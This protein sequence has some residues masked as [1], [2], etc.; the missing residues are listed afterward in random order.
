MHR[1]TFRRPSVAALL[2]LMAI[3]LAMGGTATA[4]KLI[5]GKQVRNSSLTGADVR[6][7][8]LGARDLSSAARKSL[9][10]AAG[11]GASGAAGP[12]GQTGPAGPAGPAGPK[13]DA[14]PQ[15]V[16]GPIE[17]TPAGGA[18]TG[19]YPNPQLAPTPG[20]RIEATSPVFAPA[21]NDLEF[22]FNVEV[23]DTGEMHAGLNDHLEVKR[24]GTYLIQGFLH[25]DGVANEQRQ[26]KI[27]VND[28]PVAVASH[29]DS[30]DGPTQEVTYLTRLQVGDQINLGTFQS[31]GA[32][33]PLGNLA[34]INDAALSAQWMAP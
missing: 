33:V 27:V 15:G 9:R 3:V 31:T 34:N 12:A 24:A 8:S 14:G 32:P 26:V 19:T 2:G 16:P 1:R 4:A 25:W 22:P 20:A 13:G 17:G 18:L 29:E 10:G 7:G 6:N 30:D 28:Q 5:T 11:Q 23:Y 21:G